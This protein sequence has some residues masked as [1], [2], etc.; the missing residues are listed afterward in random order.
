M[1]KVYVFGVY[2]FLFGLVYG[3]LDSRVNLFLFSGEFLFLAL[4]EGC[5]FSKKYHLECS[6]VP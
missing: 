6:L 5:F 1:L 3:F 2:F 4:P